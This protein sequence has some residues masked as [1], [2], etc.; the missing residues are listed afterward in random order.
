MPSEENINVSKRSHVSTALYAPTFLSSE[1]ANHKNA[2]VAMSNG[3]IFV[4]DWESASFSPV[5]IDYQG[6]FHHRPWGDVVTD[7]KSHPVKM[8]RLLIAYEETA[9]IIYSLNKNR[10]I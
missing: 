9:V 10:E 2:F 7:I 6:M 3:S 8:H 4:L 1:V 5:V